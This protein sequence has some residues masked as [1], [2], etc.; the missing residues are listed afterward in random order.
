MDFRIERRHPA[1]PKTYDPQAF[2]TAKEFASRL[3]K[4]LG[5][6]LKAAVFFGSGAREG[7]RPLGSDID[8]L[9]VIDDLTVI[10]TPEVVEAYRV[11]VGKTAGEIS[12]RLHVNTMKL[13][14][15]WDYMRAGDPILINILREGIA[16]YDTG[17][18]RPA[19]MLLE[20]GRIRPTMESI[21]TYFAKAPATLI[22]S[23][24]HVLQATLDLYWAVFDAAHAALMAAGKL[25]PTPGHV[26]E[27]LEE[28]FVKT[29]RLPKKTADTAQFFY[30][31]SRK[32][33]HREVRTV[34]GRD[35]E[36]MFAH[37]EHF[38]DEMKRL[39]DEDR[40]IRHRGED[41]E[42]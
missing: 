41:H 27:L 36:T 12:K 22:N 5:V 31:L 6:F 26:P 20:K 17:F 37:A 21:W 19:Q 15:F 40:Q 10:A 18:F 29:N 42:K 35:F 25:P 8:V 14:H 32:I 7:Q 39:I 2:E 34:H 30:D 24:S 33:T 3:H 11:I 28:T 38:V 13:T 4:E 23:R 9:L 16:L 1:G